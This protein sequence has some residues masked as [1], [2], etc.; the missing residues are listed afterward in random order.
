MSV[1]G[2]TPEQV[3]EAFMTRDHRQVRE[4]LDMDPIVAAG[5]SLRHAM[6][7]EDGRVFCAADFAG[8]EMRVLL[9]LAGQRDKC[10]LLRL[11]DTGERPV[12][13]YLDMAEKIYGVE[14]GT[15]TPPDAEALKAIKTERLAERQIGKNTVLGCGFQMGK[16]KFHERYCPHMPAEFAGRVIAAYRNE[17]ASKVPELWEDLGSAS[18]DAV[19]SGRARVARCGVEFRPEDDW[20]SMLLPD[21]QIMWY[22]DPQYAGEDF[23]G[24][25]TWT[26]RAWKDG[27]WKVVHAYG[28]LQ[29]ENAVQRL[30]RGLLVSAM[31]RLEDAGYPVVM[32][33]HDEIISEP[34]TGRADQKE[35]ERIMAEPPAWAKSL[36][37]PI[38]VEGWTGRRG[39]K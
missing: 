20:L 17:W 10:E 8:I 2:R 19:C 31:R 6:I 11:G 36:G 39:R 12:D 23:R 4:R 29:T 33:I 24:N 25:P 9:A 38:A 14:P 30:A 27:Q 3:V 1:P 15:W 22:R 16:D 35:F 13:V 34:Y 32:T 5:L 7:P 26:Y 28:G 21:G 18:A 37:V